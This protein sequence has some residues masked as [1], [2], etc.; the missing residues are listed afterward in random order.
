MTSRCTLRD[1]QYFLFPLLLA[2]RTRDVQTE[3]LYTL[4]QFFIELQQPANQPPQRPS[5][6]LHL[7][8]HHRRRPCASRS[9]R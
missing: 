2:R 8:R 6:D 3:A 4:S 1:S 5:A 9:A 7:Q